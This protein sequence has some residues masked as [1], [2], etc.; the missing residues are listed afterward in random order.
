MRKGSLVA[1]INLRPRRQ[2]LMKR[3]KAR[4][5]TSK[6]RWCVAA[7]L[8]RSFLRNLLSLIGRFAPP[9]CFLSCSLGTSPLF[10]SFVSA[11]ADGSFRLIGYVGR[12]SGLSWIFV[13][14]DREE[15]LV[16]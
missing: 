15:S 8:H 9:R 13:G 2:R 10:H 7:H 16:S 6:L 14:K 11:V 4:W 1:R 3:P 12:P 5:T